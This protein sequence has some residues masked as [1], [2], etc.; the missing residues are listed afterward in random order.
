MVLILLPAIALTASSACA[1]L[2]VTAVSVS[3]DKPYTA[4][5]AQLW[6]S[7]CVDH[8]Y[9]VNTIT[10]K[11]STT[12]PCK[13]G[14]INLLDF[15]VLGTNCSLSYDFTD[16][17]A[18][19]EHRLED[20]NSVTTGR[21]YL[22]GRC[23]DDAVPWQFYCTAGR[24]SGFWTTIPVPSNWEL[25]GFGQYNYGHDGNK[26]NEQGKYRYTFVGP[27]SWAKKRIQIIFEGVMTDTEVWINGASAGPKHQGGFYP[28]KYDITNLLEFGR[29]NLLDV[30]VSKRS[31]SDSVEAAE[32]KADY[33]VFGGV[34]RPVY[35]E[36][37]P[38]QFVDWMAIDARADGTISVDVYLKYISTADNV[39]AQVVTEDGSNLG[40]PFCA[41]IS[42]SN[43]KVSLRTSCTG[44]Q[45]WSA[46]TPILYKVK[47]ALREG[48]AVIHAVTE[49][50]GFRTIE[51]RPGE[52]I[53][54]NGSKIRLKGVN[55]HSF[56]PESGRCLSRQ[57]SYDDAGLLKQMNMNAVRMSHYPPD[58]HFLEVCDELGLYV[59]NELAG[60]QKPPYD[61][62]VGR[63]L[64]KE[65][66]TCS[67][68]H[69]CILF[70][71]N[72]NEGGWNTE[73]DGDFAWYDPQ[74]RTVLHPQANFNNVDTEHY[75][76]YSSVR[77]KLNGSTIFMP[78]EFLHGLYDG[79]HGAGLNDYWNLMRSSP[80]G[81]GGFLWALID[82][83]VVRTDM[84]DSID[85]DNN[86]A[87]DGILGPYR[88][89]EGSFY[90]IREI[91]CP[92]QIPM[93]VLLADFDGTITIENHYDFTNLAKC[94]FQWQ[95]VDFREPNDS[96]TGHE[97]VASGT[98]A[99]PSAEPGTSAD[100]VIGL[101]PDWQDRDALYI[102]AIDYKDEK[103]FT[104]TWGIKK[105]IDH[106]QRIFRTGSGTVTA[107][108]DNGTLVVTTGG[109]EAMFDLNNGKLINVVNDR[110][111]YS[112]G[113]G[114]RLVPLTSSL[115]TVNH[116][117]EPDH[118]VVEAEN[119]NG[120]K[121]F[122]WK[123]FPSGWLSLYYQYELFGQFDYFGITFDYPE[124][125]VLGMKWL[126]HGAY[127][128]WK[129]RTKGTTLD[130][131][132][133]NYNDNIP[134]QTWQYPEF[135]GY[136]ADLQWLVVQTKQ[137]P[138]IVANDTVDLFF[139]MY[140]PHGG[141]NPQST[142]V[143]FPDGDI[144]F[145]H[146]ISPI[147]TKF[148]TPDQLGPESQKNQADGTY[149]GTLYFYFGER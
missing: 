112:F 104:W 56:W 45:T 87:P 35:L 122:R 115:P 86:H 1:E 134:G 81:A 26:S 142:V 108:E 133:N 30:V 55:R 110:Q 85:V 101:P 65:M 78:T 95:L 37:L 51:V 148:K 149:E 145:L 13:D 39:T 83:G 41:T 130:V 121:L 113:N 25:Q 11:P 76:S 57:I 103:I 109:L 19:T 46:E 126:G 114:P 22:S 135:K 131:W 60:W 62:D 125:Q 141:I 29:T 93:E 66:V 127:R 3:A 107:V 75:E 119:A 139:R 59:L 43:D 6:G 7:V 2:A 99:G 38:P 5:A 105:P 102:S 34:Y 124:Q 106:R 92:I 58:G 50:F 79:G 91:W 84:N 147:G 70:W 89:K 77:N 116:W 33:W 69:P 32:R 23:K 80:L 129:N 90:T 18:I 28:F 140:V 14:K 61:T 63:K 42:G 9:T 143:A 136:Y 67:V 24:K 15:G 12:D 10:D 118:Y 44:H 47:L 36:V 82:E 132:Q 120:L 4:A 138:I 128:V 20:I 94:S 73:L 48:K 31:S 68:N 117:P 21:V 98:I 123:I 111:R 53:F 27:E 137:G 146:A 72:G 96:N 54:L 64:V 17:E 49:R 8:D 40:E 52:G 74:N 88:E 144:S 16:L 100:V 97:V 71:D